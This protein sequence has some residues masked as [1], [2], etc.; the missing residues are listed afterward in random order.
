[1]DTIFPPVLEDFKLAFQLRFGAT[2]ECPKCHNWWGDEIRLSVSE[3]RRLIEIAE[4]F[5]DHPDLMTPRKMFLEQA[6]EHFNSCAGE[7]G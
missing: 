6:T 1:M 2:Y 5:P 4:H 7:A 3:A